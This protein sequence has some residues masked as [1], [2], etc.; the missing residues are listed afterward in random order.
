MPERK[1]RSPTRTASENGKSP[2]P[3]AERK[4]T[5]GGEAATSWDEGASGVSCD[6]ADGPQAVSKAA[7]RNRAAL[8]RRTAGERERGRGI[9]GGLERRGKGN[10]KGKKPRK[11]PVPSSAS[12]TVAS[13]DD[14]SRKQPAALPT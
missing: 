8:R 5:G 9:D 14:G 6:E 2:G 13:E 10:Q 7:L 12:P 4:A 1:S 3:G 11:A